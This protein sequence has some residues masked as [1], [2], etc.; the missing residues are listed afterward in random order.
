MSS[1][2]KI[3]DTTLRDGEQ[4]PGCS[5]HLPEKIEVARRLEQ[6]RVDVMEA[7]FAASSPGD[8]ESVA[9]VARAVKDCSVAS[10]ARCIER[11]IDAAYEALRGA[12][13]PRIHVFLATSPIH[14]ACKLKMTPEQVLERVA[15]MVAYA[16]RYCP[17]IEFSAEDA[18]RSEPD[19]LAQVVRVAIRSGASVINIPD[20]VG[21]TT[22]GEMRAAIEGL[23]AAVPE[24]EGVTL[25][26]HCHNDL[27]M[28]SANSL[29]GVLGGAR[30]VECTVN[31]L[32]ERA[33]NA[34]LEEVVMAL[35]TRADLYRA[36]TRIDTTQLY[37]ASK[38]VYSV[39]GRTVPFNKPIVGP[40]AFAHE[41]GIHQHGVLANRNTYEIMR[42]EDIGIPSN[43][44]ILGKHSGRHAFEEK[45]GAMGIRLSPEE[46]ERTFAAFKDLCDKKKEV[47]DSDIEALV[48]DRMPQEEGGLY[49]LRAFTVHTGSTEAATAVITLERDGVL[50]EDVA[51]GNGPVDAAYKAVDKL[52]CPPPF[53]FGNYVIQSV[54]EGK[55]SLG[56]VL[57][58][59]RYEDKTF[60][61]K[62]LS[63]DVIEASILSY[64]HTLNKLMRYCQSKEEHS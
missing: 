34:P 18:M 56:E 58:T 64:V 16:R 10:L 21:Y 44:I 15:A 59:L 61:A 36:H 52:V 41:A 29:A 47:T 7:G 35:R 37:R 13:S 54:S 19:F 55:D 17:D 45:L 28:A 27:G 23:R 60:S 32:G 33:G 62:G 9:A 43:K 3:F 40:N 46:S 12:V 24:C 20:T 4:A 48:L 42:P 26:V 53:V 14:M 5:M 38:A 2:V 6:L 8:F 50:S 22:P 63:T 25:S 57:T 30:Q 49:T 31:G 1:Q 11:D 51:L 39:I